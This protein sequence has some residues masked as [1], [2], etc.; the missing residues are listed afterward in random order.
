[1]SKHFLTGDSVWVLMSKHFL[2]GDFPMGD[3]VQVLM[4]KQFL[5]GDSHPEPFSHGGLSPGVDE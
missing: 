5:T 2:T 3:S 4:S 1:M